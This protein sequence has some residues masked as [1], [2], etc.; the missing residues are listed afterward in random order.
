MFLYEDDYASNPDMIAE[1]LDIFYSHDVC[2][3]VPYDYFDRSC[4]AQAGAH[5]VA[6]PL[7]R[8]VQ[9]GGG[10]GRRS[11]HWPQGWSFGLEIA[12]LLLVRDAR[13]RLA[14]SALQ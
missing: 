4:E 11:S 6:T 10:G 1:M 5:G 14:G 3:A 8:A 9:G 7:L 12:Q 2:M 13:R